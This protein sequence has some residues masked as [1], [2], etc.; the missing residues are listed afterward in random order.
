MNRAL[1]FGILPILTIFLHA[2]CPASF[3]QQFSKTAFDATYDCPRPG[4]NLR[5][6]YDGQRYI[7]TIHT[8]TGALK[9][10]L[11]NNQS[12]YD[13][14]MKKATTVRLKE[15]SKRV[16]VPFD[17]FFNLLKQYF[18]DWKH[19]EAIPGARSLGTQQING[20]QCQGW[21][22][23]LALPMDIWV[24][25]QNWSVMREVDHALTG[26]VE[27]TQTNYTEKKYDIPFYTGHK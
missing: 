4:F 26:D 9:D 24:D 11:P 16:E 19:P 25:T 5:L 10:L 23:K 20:R 1:V 27:V 3:A 2:S 15:G 7:R 12:F 21:N 6:L 17:P 13:L 22:V 8:S 18:L 14:K